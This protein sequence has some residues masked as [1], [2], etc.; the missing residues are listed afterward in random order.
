[1]RLRL[2]VLGAACVAAGIAAACANPSD[3]PGGP[4]DA[5]APV[6]MRI[7]PDSGAVVGRPTSVTIQFDEVISETPRGA[8]DLASLVFISPKSGV[9]EVD[10]NR[11]SISIKPSRGWKANTVY[12]ITVNPG[13]LDLQQNALDSTIRTVFSTGGDIP[14]TRLSGAAFD[15]TLGKPA[16]RALIEALAIDSARKDTTFY[17]ALADSSGRFEL[18]YLPAGPYLL[19]AVLD[20]N[21]NRGLEPLEPWDTVRVTVTQSVVADLYAFVHD[22]VGLRISDIAVSDSGRTLKLTFDKPFAPGQLWTPD[23]VRVVKPDSSVLAVARVTTPTERATADSLRAKAVADSTMR[24]NLDTT[25]AGRARADSAARR[26]ATD[27]TANAERAAR[28]ARRLALLRGERPVVRDTTPPP[29]FQRPLLYNELF[30]TLAQPLP[31]NTRLRVEVTGA[32][33]LSGIARNATREFTT[34]KAP[35]VVK[36]DSVP[37][38]RRDTTSTT[39]TT[40]SSRT[41]RARRQ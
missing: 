8:Q 5:N 18:R 39:M 41:S 19:R 28:E 24:A 23:R 4:P 26:R 21:S 15:W 31:D 9:P 10:W 32:R 3:P 22:T 11:S 12:S 25:T 30:V 20:R 7:T 2:A 27:S 29:K 40:S 6:V 17:Q 34:P 16:P 38:V 13:I 14:N 37:P 35:P 36:K 33:G 1:M